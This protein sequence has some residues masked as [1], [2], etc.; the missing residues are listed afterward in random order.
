ML[1]GVQTSQSPFMGMKKG[2]EDERS[3]TNALAHTWDP[4][5]PAKPALTAVWE[6]ISQYITLK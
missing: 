1:L 3:Q 2:H 4:W 6:K 5:T